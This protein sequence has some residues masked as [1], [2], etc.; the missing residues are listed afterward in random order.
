MN[1][2]QTLTVRQPGA[3]ARGDGGVS[4]RRSNGA[5]RVLLVCVL[6]T[7]GACGPGG[8]RE[9]AVGEAWVGP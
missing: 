7:L 2:L 3:D 5:L 9:R 1:Y 6:A 4:S 8:E